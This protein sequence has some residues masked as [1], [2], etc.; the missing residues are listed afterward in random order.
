LTTKPQGPPN[1]QR[2]IARRAGPAADPAA[3]LGI[4]A[5]VDCDLSAIVNSIQLARFALAKVSQAYQR[6]LHK[7]Q[8]MSEELQQL[9]DALESVHKAL[10]EANAMNEDLNNR[11]AGLKSMLD[12]LEQVCSMDQVLRA[13]VEAM[14]GGS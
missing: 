11:A 8:M 12:D 13:M 10:L 7:N 4:L 14:I 6:E 2:L 5:T 3:D 1:R 9:R